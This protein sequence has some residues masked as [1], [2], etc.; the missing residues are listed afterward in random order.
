MMNKDKINSVHLGLISGLVCII[1][2][3]FIV[4]IFKS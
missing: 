4:I 3:V 1:V 2:F